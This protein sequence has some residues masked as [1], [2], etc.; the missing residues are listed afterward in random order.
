MFIIQSIV[1]IPNS[2]FTKLKGVQN[3][4]ATFHYLTFCHQLLKAD[5]R[6]TN[7]KIKK[8]WFYSIS[9]I[10]QTNYKFTGLK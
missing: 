7:T 2:S 1:P 10:C 5:L 3:V 6:Y 8:K 9:P 4:D